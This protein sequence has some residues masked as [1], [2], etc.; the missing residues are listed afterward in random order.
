MKGKEVASLP[1][2]FVFGTSPKMILAFLSLVSH[3]LPEL[4][5]DECAIRKV[6]VSQGE[7]SVVVQI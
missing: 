2:I 1:I 7:E 5:W 6:L 3:I 4:L